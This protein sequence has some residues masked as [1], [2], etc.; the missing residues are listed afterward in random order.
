[1]G[2]IKPLSGAK[3]TKKRRNVPVTAE[4]KL[5]MIELHQQGLSQAEI[6]RKM[7]VPRSTLSDI[8]KAK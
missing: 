8:I 2:K 4:T 7:A 5:R 3:D 1:M 6:C